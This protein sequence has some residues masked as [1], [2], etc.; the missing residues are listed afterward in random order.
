VKET[1]APYRIDEYGWSREIAIEVELPEGLNVIPDRYQANGRVLQYVI[2]G[3]RRPG[4]VAQNAVSQELCG[5]TSAQGGTDVFKSVPE[6]S[7]IDR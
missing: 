4:I 2:G 5:M 3:G 6:L 7:I 1:T